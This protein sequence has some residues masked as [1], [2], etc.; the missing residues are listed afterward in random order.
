MIFFFILEKKAKSS[1]CSY[2]Y[3]LVT[4]RVLQKARFNVY[5]EL[6]PAGITSD[7]K[8]FQATHNNKKFMKVSRKV[9][10]PLSYQK[11]YH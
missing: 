3:I 9:S 7:A 5:S 6:R 8:V 4:N 1:P 2:K 10:L 11:F